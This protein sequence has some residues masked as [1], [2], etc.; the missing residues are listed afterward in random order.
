MTQP[1]KTTARTVKPM[2][3]VLGEPP[4]V[5]LLDD[6][7]PASAVPPPDGA[8]VGTGAGEPPLV[9]LLDDPLPASAVPLPDGVMDGTGADGGDD[10]D[11]TGALPVV[12]LLEETPLIEVALTLFELLEV[13]PTL[14]KGVG[15]V[16]ACTDTG[17]GLALDVAGG[18]LPEFITAVAVGTITSSRVTLRLSK[19]ISLE[20][21]S[22]S[23]G[24]L[25]TYRVC[26]VDGSKAIV[27][28]VDWG[29]LASSV[30]VGSV[31]LTVS[32]KHSVWQLTV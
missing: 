9:L 12:A 28:S 24:M 23:L 14:L 13:A 8:M 11:A 29:A 21:F 19:L 10:A 1:V 5:L 17:A 25:Y 22:R 7:L 4:L 32:S 6:P 3:S 26:W 16:D 15:E 30:T 27:N 20:A 31:A 18:G 2:A